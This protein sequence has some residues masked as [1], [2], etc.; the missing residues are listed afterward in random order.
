MDRQKSLIVQFMGFAFFI[1]TSSTPI[2]SPSHIFLHFFNLSHLL[3]DF[4]ENT[5]RFLSQNIQNHNIEIYR[6][7]VTMKFSSSSSFNFFVF[8]FRNTHCWILL[9]TRKMVNER[10]ILKFSLILCLNLSTND[11]TYDMSISFSFTDLI[12]FFLVRK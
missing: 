5:H 3:F 4:F 11:G 10:W 6:I 2:P 1:S 9:L 8:R 7:T 12:G